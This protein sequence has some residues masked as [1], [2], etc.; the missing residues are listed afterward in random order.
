[1]LYLENTHEVTCILEM[2]GLF[3]PMKVLTEADF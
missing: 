3:F 2:S 1:M